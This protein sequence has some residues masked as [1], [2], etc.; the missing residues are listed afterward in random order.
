MAKECALQYF[1]EMNQNCGKNNQDDL[2]KFKNCE[3][4]VFSTESL[5]AVND[6]CGANA[7]SIFMSPDSGYVPDPFAG[8]NGGN[9]GNGSKAP[10]L[11]G[12]GINVTQMVKNDD[13]M[14]QCFLNDTR[15]PIIQDSCAYAARACSMASNPVSCL[16]TNERMPEVRR[17]AEAIVNDCSQQLSPDNY[18][19]ERSSKIL[20]SDVGDTSKYI[21]NFTAKSC[22]ELKPCVAGQKDTG[23]P[24][25]PYLYR[26]MENCS[27]Y[28]GT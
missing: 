20:C 5:K 24:T 15:F 12:C 25:G 3:S 2:Q 17:Y 21:C 1:S 4:N 18:G 7:G 22:S 28:C 11:S 26:D 27:Q 23:V 9:D 16:S 14:A 10:D 13:S 19:P 8:G 6:R